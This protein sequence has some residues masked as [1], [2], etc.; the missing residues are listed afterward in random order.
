MR[1]RF[2]KIMC[3][4]S[5]LTLLFSYCF[6]PNAQ[7]YNDGR[8]DTYINMGV[9]AEKNNYKIPNMF[10]QDAPYS[11]ITQFPLVVHSGT[12]YVPLSMFILYP[13][14]QVNYSGM[15]ENFYLVNTRNGNYISFHVEQ[16]LAYTHSG[17]LM[18]MET[19]FFYQTRYIP[20]RKAAD[21]LDMMCET[22]DD[23]LS[24]IYAFR[25]SC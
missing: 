20:A 10:R 4:F 17:E 18:K 19:K 23:P 11:N 8:F 15:D 16:N 12:E 3:L 25:I 22:Y 13:Y 24:G 6:I 14:I 5:V 7:S 9:S 2:I 21:V 1:T